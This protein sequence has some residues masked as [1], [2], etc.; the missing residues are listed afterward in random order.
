MSVA[1]IVLTA[2]V[3]GFALLTLLGAWLALHPRPLER[4]VRSPPSLPTDH[5]SVHETFETRT[6]HGIVLR[7]WWIPSPIQPA[8]ATILGL[9]GSASPKTDWSPFPALVGPRGY[10]LVLCDAKGHGESDEG[11][12]TWGLTEWEDARGVLDA[13]QAAGRPVDRVVAVGTSLGA[14]TAIRLAAEDPR[15]VALVAQSA[16]TSI[17]QAFGDL[18]GRL[19][20]P[21]GRI[22]SW[23]VT[24]WVRL[25]AK[26]P[27]MVEASTLDAARRVRVPTLIVQGSADPVVDERHARELFEAVGAADKTFILVDGGGHV[28]LWKRNHPEYREQLLAFLDRVTSPTAR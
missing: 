3:V 18:S 25:I 10:D 16:Y 20:G 4:W 7:G 21:P 9:V 23:A 2:L 11:E 15:V 27:D 13:L 8:R 19:L 12:V 26:R 1:W 17:R 28:S 14:V 24:C 6:P 5:G 22:F